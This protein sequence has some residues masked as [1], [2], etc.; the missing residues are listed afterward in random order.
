[1]ERD[2]NLNTV[3]TNIGL[4]IPFLEE[5]KKIK[6]LKKNSVPMYFMSLCFFIFPICT[7]YMGKIIMS[8]LI[9]NNTN[10][11]SDLFQSAI[12]GGGGET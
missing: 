12:G 5:Y 3:V 11:R 4:Q 9:M 8:Q 10:A 6:S 1:M 7:R 2:V